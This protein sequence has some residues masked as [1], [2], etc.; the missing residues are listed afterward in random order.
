M[1]AAKCGRDE[2]LAAAPKAA[3]SARRI[4]NVH[5]RAAGPAVA[6]A[7]AEAA[8]VPPA[9]GAP[10]SSARRVVPRTL[11]SSVLGMD[12]SYRSIPPVPEAV[13]RE[14]EST[15]VAVAA[16]GKD[17]DAR[18]KAAGSLEGAE[19]G[20]SGGP[21]SPFRA[22]ALAETI[23]SAARRRR[24]LDV[25]GGAPRRP[26]AASS[27]V[28][29]PPLTYPSPLPLPVVT[30]S[31]AR[32]LARP[33]APDAEP[34]TWATRGADRSETPLGEVRPRGAIHDGAVG[35]GILT[36][37]DTGAAAP[38]AASVGARRDTGLP[39]RP[40][41]T[42]LGAPA[43]VPPCKTGWRGWSCQRA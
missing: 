11:T 31:A 41:G 32:P 1:A 36:R 9:L 39:A 34:V 43:P 5:C 13:L 16:A 17:G 3:A 25:L 22:A 10:A 8:A 14:D 42:P 30:V 19:V 18:T 40:T 29:S 24:L 33:A 28:A 2:G 26:G 37:R 35:V 7:A 27:G 4:A 15:D 12:L 21:P 23:A 38:Q 6:A 20:Q